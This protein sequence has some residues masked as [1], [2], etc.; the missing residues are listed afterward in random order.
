MEYQNVINEINLLRNRSESAAI[1]LYWM[2]HDMDMSVPDIATLNAEELIAFVFSDEQMRLFADRVK[3]QKREA[4]K[5]A[6]GA[7]KSAE[8]SKMF[9]GLSR[10]ECVA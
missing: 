6:M 2:M 1:T 8:E 7:F 5:R 9:S 3:I 10:V 4:I